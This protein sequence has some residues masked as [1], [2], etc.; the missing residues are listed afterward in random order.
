MSNITDIF[1]NV[2]DST[3]NY[4]HEY[5]AKRLLKS[6]V[7]D[8]G[9]ENKD[10]KLIITILYNNE[11]TKAYI[12]TLEEVARVFN[13][14]EAFLDIENDTISKIIKALVEKRTTKDKLSGRHRSFVKGI[15]IYF[16][17]LFNYNSKTHH[18][19]GKIKTKKSMKKKPTHKIRRN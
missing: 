4:I 10:Y 18:K 13:T 6:V 8:G 14:K 2:V 5:A 12:Y 19:G 3:D 17:Y 16:R 9:T 7:R 1:W 11:P 15:P